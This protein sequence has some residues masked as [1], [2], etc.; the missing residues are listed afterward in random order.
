MCCSD[1]FRLIPE[2]VGVPRAA[3]LSA[4]GL[5]PSLLEAQFACVCPSSACGCVGNNRPALGRLV[6]R[7]LGCSAARRSS[8]LRL[9]T[10]LP[11]T[12]DRAVRGRRRWICPECACSREGSGAR[13]LGQA[14]HGRAPASPAHTPAWGPRVTRAPLYAWGNAGSGLCSFARADLPGGPRE[15]GGER[16]TSGGGDAGAN[17]CLRLPSPP[18]RRGG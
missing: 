5:A 2:P 18:G 15:A 8:K 6:A 9:L 4:A 10:R 13:G 14:L 12:G 17:D 16:R 3:L 11:F 1:V 7:L